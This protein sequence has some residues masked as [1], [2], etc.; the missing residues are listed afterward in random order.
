MPDPTDTAAELS[1]ADGAEGRHEQ[2]RDIL[3]ELRE[4]PETDEA[5]APPDEPEPEP[6]ADDEEERIDGFTREQIAGMLGEEALDELDG[7][8]AASDET[9]AEQSAHPSSSVAVRP[10]PVARQIA[11]PTS[12]LLLAMMAALVVICALGTWLTLR[13]VASSSVT[14][15]R[16]L[17]ERRAIDAALPRPQA[18]APGPHGPPE[19]AAPLAALPKLDRGLRYTQKMDEAAQLFEKEDYEAAAAAY[20]EALVVMPPNWNDGGGAFRLG[21][22][23]SRLG[24]HRLA[25]AYYRRVAQAYGDRY[26]ARALYQLGEAHLALADYQKAREALYDL[27]LTQHRYGPQA[28]PWIEK[29]HYRL[30]HC[31]WAEAEN[32]TSPTPQPGPHGDPPE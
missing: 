6:P 7:D 5:P 9:P 32:L 27:L 2:I 28:Q 15:A 24:K 19:P 13:Q 23:Y 8:D 4:G 26:Q 30:A 3:A 22:T 14:V 16:V 18:P 1:R 20:R 29:A 11:A 12:R 21:E 10:Q 25:V 17:N 31:Y